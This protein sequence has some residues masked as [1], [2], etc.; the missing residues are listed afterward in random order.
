MSSKMKPCKAVVLAA[1]HDKAT[2]DL[3]LRPLANSTVI[4]QSLANVTA[5]VPKSEV[6]VVV[7]EHDDS[8]REFLGDS[9]NYVIQTVQ[10]GTGDA[11]RCARFELEG[12]DG[13][14][15]IAYAD[16]PML[17]SSSLRGLLWQHQ[18][19]G[20]QFSLLTA[21]LP[22]PGEY[23]RVVRDSDGRISQIVEASDLS[24]EFAPI[25]EVNVGAYVVDNAIL[26]PKL[27]EMAAVDEHRLTELAKKLIAEGGSLASYAIFD[28]DE[29]QGINT[30]DELAAAADIVLKR[31]F[32]PSHTVETGDISFGTGGWRALIGEAFT[33]HNVR[34]LS[35]AVANEVIRQGQEKAGVVIG[36]DRRFLSREAVRSSAEVF[37]GNNISVKVLPDGVSTPLG[38]FAVPYTGCWYGLVV[39]A[40]HNPPEWN[41]IK[42]FRSDGSL[43]LEDE[44]N[45]LQSEANSLTQ[46]DVV[47]LDYSIAKM[48]GVIQEIDLTNAYVDYVEQF[49]DVKATREKSDLNVIVDPMFGTSQLTLGM[50]LSDARVRADFIHTGHDPLFGGHPPVPN[51]DYLMEL[52]DLVKTTSTCELGLAT[53]GDADRVGIVDERG[54]WVS[55]NDLLVV[56]YWYLHEV[57]GLKGGVVRN[58]STTHMLDRMAKR[59][60]EQSMEVPVG[61]K[62]ITAGMDQID[63]LM[64]GESS[65]G[66]TIRGYMKGKDGIFACALICEILSVTGKKLSQLLDKMWSMIG[67]LHSVEKGIPATPAMRVELPRRM[68]KVQ[69][70]E[71]CGVKVES[72]TTIDGIKIRLVDGSWVLLRFSGTEPVLRMVAEAEN[73]KCASALVNWAKEFA[74]AESADAS[75]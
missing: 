12:F 6:I 3:L 64:G 27:D 37:A 60:G 44:T 15:L 2:R 47:S 63:A 28:T 72:I 7:D 69:L 25:H 21:M 38:T 75:K 71:V 45:R 1:G 62:H 74:T 33:I 9:W 29:V 48:S 51:P 65:G 52:T 58:L 49:V 50:I 8:I 16:T 13:N 70:T 54:N 10:A 36:G 26:I 41:G 31:I 67:R 4:E 35:Q 34:R 53:D 19:K 5:V 14:V 40:S 43:P 17:R 42:V 55:T 73:E 59:F 30:D 22:D 68:A 18:L 23:G 24:A 46:A 20:A 11:V 32:A 66:L 39:T 57:R 61:F 56:F